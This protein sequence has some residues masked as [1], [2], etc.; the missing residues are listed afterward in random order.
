MVRPSGRSRAGHRETGVHHVS[1]P[2]L[3]LA[4][5][6]EH[7]GP[8]DRG[9]RYED[10]LHDALESAGLGAVTGGGS[11]LSET[12][13]I[14]FADV[15]FELHDLQAALDVVVATLDHAGA[16]VYS[17]I[18]YGEQVVRQFGRQ[19]CLA[20]Y[21]DG[22]S[23]PDEVY[24]GLDF[25]ATMGS[26]EALAGPRSYRGFWQGPEETGVFFFGSSADDMFARTEPLLRQLPIGQNARVV[27][28]RGKAGM[29]SRSL[30][31]PRH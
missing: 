12:G 3:V 24:T 4:R 30:R 7:I 22:I 26:I 8:I 19:E 18:L 2:H 25:E 17:E 15:E 10:P 31:L 13:E 16:P 20:I 27:I 29:H 6:H 14:E 9:S 11:Q 28:G 23:L 5:F 1:S 21:L